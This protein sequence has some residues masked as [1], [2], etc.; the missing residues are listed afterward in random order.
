VPDTTDKATYTINVER[1]NI[2]MKSVSILQIL[3]ALQKVGMCLMF[4]QS[5]VAKPKKTEDVDSDVD[6]P[7]GDYVKDGKEKWITYNLTTLGRDVVD[8]FATIDAINTLNTD[9]SKIVIDG[10]EV[11]DY[12]KLACFD[13]FIRP[14]KAIVAAETQGIKQIDMLTTY[15][16]ICDVFKGEVLSP[17]MFES[18]QLRCLRAINKR[19]SD[20]IKT[21]GVVRDSLVLTEDAILTKPVVIDGTLK[22][23]TRGRQFEIFALKHQFYPT[24]EY[25]VEYNNATVNEA[26]ILFAQDVVSA[27][28]GR[29]VSDSSEG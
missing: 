10:Y 5:E 9:V 24:R 29:D 13:R 6:I 18:A 1:G 21:T 23:V 11:G 20:L 2:Q 22:A 14:S 19:C 7:Q 15:E 3:T 17:A 27:A 12:H 4:T 28:N 8:I 26:M 25:I 16:P